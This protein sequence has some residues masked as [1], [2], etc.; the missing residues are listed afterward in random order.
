MS[1]W[2]T[3]PV[4]SSA[5]AVAALVFGQTTTAPRRFEWLASFAAAREVQAESGRPILLYFPAVGGRGDLAIVEALPPHLG[6]P[7]LV[8]GARV[9]A[10]EVLDLSRRFRLKKLPALVLI[11]RAGRSIAGWEGGA[12]A[13]LLER[14][15]SAVRK[16][17]EAD[18]R[19]LKVVE[20]A[21]EL[22]RG[23]QVEGAYLKAVPSLANNAVAPGILA[24]VRAIEGRYLDELWGQ[25]FR[26]LAGEGLK[27]DAELL[28]SL[29]VLRT[30]GSHLAFQ[31]A[32][33]R[34]ISRL[35]SSSIGAR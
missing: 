11:D 31:A 25:A 16:L 18:A 35:E 10:D 21:E 5:W 29:K 30:A 9:S 2:A 22:A 7:P 6:R 33:A 12:P 27:P 3:V 20:E 17:D 8:E 1:Q 4:L 14:I 13:D 23:G 26:I 24:R 34:E 32:M 19:E 15:Q 28:D